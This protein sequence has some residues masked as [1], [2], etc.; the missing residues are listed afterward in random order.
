MP[1]LKINFFLRGFCEPP[2]TALANPPVTDPAGGNGD[3]VRFAGGQSQV[4]GQLTIPCCLLFTPGSL[5]PRHG[6]DR[7]FSMADFCQCSSP[8]VSTIL[9]FSQKQPSTD[10]CE[11]RRESVGFTSRKFSEIL[12][13]LLIEMA[14]SSSPPF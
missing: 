13:Y 5:V 11:M 10:L 3:E 12:L 2:L 14:I 4:A 9:S 1:A 8:L 6:L 7:A